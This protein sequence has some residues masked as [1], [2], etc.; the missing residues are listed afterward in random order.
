MLF[1]VI[2]DMII[3]AM[4]RIRRLSVSGPGIMWL[5]QVSCITIFIEIIAKSQKKLWVHVGQAGA[6]CY[7]LSWVANC[8][9][10]FTTTHEVLH[11]HWPFCV[12]QFI[13]QFCSFATCIRFHFLINCEGTHDSQEQEGF[14]SFCMLACNHVFYR[15]GGEIAPLAKELRSALERVWL[16]TCSVSIPT[17]STS[18]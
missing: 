15:R 13:K 18:S 3:S 11:Q 8:R 10:L 17:R 4:A 14:G 7:V 2:L 16:A 6:V 9:P 12:N 5:W 1:L